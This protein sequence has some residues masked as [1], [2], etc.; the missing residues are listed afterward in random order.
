MPLCDENSR[1][2]WF[3]GPFGGIPVRCGGAVNGS[4]LEHLSVA[5][6][7]W[8]ALVLMF[9]WAYVDITSRR[10]RGLTVTWGWKILGYLLCG[11][12]LYFLF[13]VLDNGREKYQ[14]GIVVRTEYTSLP[15]AYLQDSASRE[16]G[17]T[18]IRVEEIEFSVG[19]VYRSA[20]ERVC[21]ETSVGRF[22]GARRHEL[23][24]DGFC[25]AAER[26]SQ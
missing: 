19:D 11:Y 1:D 18:R 25:E 5:V 10:R 9:W 6:L 20:G 3:Q 26:G 21:V 15:V 14:W 16:A 8:G 24:S 17:V 22:T 4:E 12:L 23:V 13:G 7:K 2:A